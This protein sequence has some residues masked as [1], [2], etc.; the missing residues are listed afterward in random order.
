MTPIGTDV[1]YADALRGAF[2]DAAAAFGTVQFDH[3]LAG[4]H[5]RLRFAGPALAAVLAPAFEHLAGA[6]PA[7]RA[8]LCISAWD[9]ATAGPAPPPP[10]SL[11]RYATRDRVLGLD[12][13]HLRVAY[14]AGHGLLSVLRPGSGSGLF[15]AA[16]SAR[17]PRWVRRM[18]FRH[19]LGWWAVERGLTLLHAAAV[20][21]AGAC[22]ILPGSSGSGKSTTALA[23]S[24][25]GLDFLADDLCLLDG[26][27]GTAHAV[28][29]W[30]KAEADAVAR[31]PALQARIVATEDGQSLLRPAGLV[32]AA[33][34]VGVVLPHVT[35]RAATVTRPANAAEAL[36]ALGPSTVIEGNG[37]GQASLAMF[38]GLAQRVPAVHLDLGTDIDGV[39]AVLEGLVRRWAA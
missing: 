14:D 13:Q 21:W 10:W 26:A 12:E 4:R 30:A 24:E 31:I 33:R 37:A 15:Y 28:Y 32:G 18:P 5:V 34:I 27:A 25:A 6:D 36:L 19:L 16:D 20:G 23:A 2:E 7:G 17:T 1:A 35:G 38:A 3:L 9:R 22:V 39:V 11:D 29:G 8:E